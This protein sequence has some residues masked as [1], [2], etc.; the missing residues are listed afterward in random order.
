M[1][2]AEVDLRPR[3]ILIAQRRQVSAGFRDLAAEILA[4]EI[5]SPP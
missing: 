2:F 5:P 1:A 4:A 3:E